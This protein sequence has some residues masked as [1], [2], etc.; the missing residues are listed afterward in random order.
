MNGTEVENR[1]NLDFL[2]ALV[3]AICAL[4]CALFPV[5]VTVLPMIG[6]DIL[7]TPAAELT[8]ISSAVVF[9]I[10]AGVS[11]FFR[12]HRKRRVLLL[13]GLGSLA[14][15]LGITLLPASFERYSSVTGGL[16]L[17]VAHLLNHKYSYA[18]HADHSR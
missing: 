16:I 5:L 10:F 2:G 15:V 4:H 14:L 3:S 17:I 7:T 6:L 18:D 8:L 11:G 1:F 13:F 12:K 9:A